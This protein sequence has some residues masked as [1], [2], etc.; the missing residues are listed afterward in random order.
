VKTASVIYL[1]KITALKSLE[2]YAKQHP[3]V[4]PFIKRMLKRQGCP[5]AHRPKKIDKIH[6]TPFLK[7]QKRNT[8][9]LLADDFTIPYVI[10]NLQ[11]DIFS[12]FIVQNIPAIN[13]M[14]SN[15]T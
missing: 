6:C 14:T 4:N 8:S 13:P 2:R 11:I 7:K 9:A 5:T 1:G 10:Q 15:I 3:D 12:C